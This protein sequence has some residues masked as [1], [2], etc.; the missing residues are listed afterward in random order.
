[1][2]T[3]IMSDIHGASKKYY[4]MLEKINIDFE[5]DVLIIDGDVLDRNKGSL[6]LFFEIYEMQKKYG[7]DHLVI[8]KG[9]HELFL[10]RYIKG[11][12]SE[13]LYSAF[14]GDTTISEV[15]RLTV[16][17]KT[18]LV[19]IL[20][21]LPI[22]KKVYSEKRG[23]DILVVHTG[24]LPRFITECRENED[25]DILD[26]IEKSVAF[27]EY[28]F[29]INAYIQAEAP[30]YVRRNLDCTICVGHVPTS[31]V[32]D[33]QAPIIVEMPGK[34]VILI[35]CGAGYGERLGCLRIDDEAVFYV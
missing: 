35:D 17:E 19:D 26:A 21:G 7:S 32:I 31:R 30:A 2:S 4:S 24:P 34:K 22:Y 11:E 14:G 16:E 5:T 33:V 25:I 8:L 1:M 13:S 20:E 6:K 10:S 12:L 28:K 9:N 18:E 23:E 15:S 29:L 3:Y 27:D